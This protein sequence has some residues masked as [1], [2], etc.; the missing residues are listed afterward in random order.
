MD[1]KRI[2]RGPIVYILLAIAAVW[3]GSSLLTGSGFREVTTQEGLDLLQGN[4]VESAK[5]VDGEQ[6]VDLTLAN[7][8]AE[9]GTQVQFYYV[10]PRGIEVVEAICEALDRLAPAGRRHREQIRLVTDRPGHDQRYAIDPRK[11][12]TEIG[13]KAR[14]SVES[15]L[16]RTVRWYLANEAWWRPLRKQHYAGE[17][18]GL[19]VG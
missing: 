11:T 2:F 7:A 5:I 9:N 15:G 6:R 17:R 1:F 18:L 16:D 8:D 19:I 13:W 4:N 3:I 14:E 12:E 10:E